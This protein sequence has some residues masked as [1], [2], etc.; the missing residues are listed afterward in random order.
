MSGSN[1]VVPKTQG[2]VMMAQFV[3]NATSV[4]MSAAQ[5]EGKYRY[6]I[7]KFTKA[8][9]ASRASDFGVTEADTAKGI[10]TIPQK[11]EAMCPQFET[12]NGWFGHLQKFNPTSII[13][14]TEGGGGSDNN[15]NVD[16]ND[17]D[18]YGGVGYDG[19]GKW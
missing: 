12:W 11:L 13:S 18:G 16:G 8:N 10:R 5:A 4:L 9:T 15:D 2:F 17:G 14:S 1:Q 19:D 6:M 3:S 7:G